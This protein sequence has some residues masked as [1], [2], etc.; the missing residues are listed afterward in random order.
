[1]TLFIRLLDAENKAE[2]MA[3]AVAAVRAGRAHPRVF[4]VN[5][6]SFAQVPGSPFAYWVSENVRRLFE[7]LPPFEADGR[8]VRVGLQTSDDF[9]FLRIWWE[10]KDYINY[11]IP[12]A[13]GGSYSPFYKEDND[14]KINWENQG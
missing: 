4:E 1:M 14:L 5:P 6:E 7:E 13:K 3:E 9:R 11:W 12:F 8:K 10:V 2:A